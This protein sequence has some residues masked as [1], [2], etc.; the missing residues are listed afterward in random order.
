MSVSVNSG[1]RPTPNEF[2]VAD[3]FILAQIFNSSCW[4]TGDALNVFFGLFFF[5]LNAAYIGVMHDLCIVWPTSFALTSCVSPCVS[6]CV[7]ACVRGSLAWLRSCDYRGLRSIPAHP[8]LLLHLLASVSI[9]PCCFFFFFFLFL[10][11]PSV[12]QPALSLS[13]CCACVFLGLLVSVTVNTLATWHRSTFLLDRAHR[14]GQLRVR[15]FV[16]VLARV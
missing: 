9:H 14:K 13:L 10:A 16:C 1:L 12:P 8:L 15:V 6:V 3:C 7:C 4:A 5:I 2:Y 11:S